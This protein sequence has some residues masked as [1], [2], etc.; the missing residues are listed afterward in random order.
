MNMK[1]HII[2]ARMEQFDDREGLLATLNE[3]QIIAPRFDLDW[4]IKDVMGHLWAWQ[5]ISI[6]RVEGGVH[7]REPGFPKWV[8]DLGDDWEENAD[9]V[10][11]LTYEN[12]HGRSWTYVHQ[13][14]KEGFLYFLDVGDKISE[15][16]LLDGSKYSWL[17]GYPLAFILVASYDHHLE[18]YEKLSGMLEGKEDN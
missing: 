18:H 5:Q 9:R 10:N 3:E 17:N 6:A 12:N 11:D 8:T 15:K 4:S 14:W 13:I 7:D 16:N 1:G 2:A